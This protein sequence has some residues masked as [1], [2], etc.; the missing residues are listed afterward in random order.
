MNTYLVAKGGCVKGSLLRVM[1]GI[2][3]LWPNVGKAG[4]G[5]Q[6]E[7]SG[8][9]S[10][11]TTNAAPEGRGGGKL[12]LTRFVKIE[13]SSMSPALDL[14]SGDPIDYGDHIGICYDKKYDKN[15][16]LKH[17]SI[18]PKAPTS[19]YWNYR[20]GSGAILGVRKIPGI[21]YT[22][23]ISPGVVAQDGTVDEAAHEFSFTTPSPV[24]D[25]EPSRLT[26]GEPY[27]YGSLEHPFPFSLTGP[28]GDQQ[29]SLMARAGVRFARI[30]YP[31]GQIEP[32]KGVYD[33]KLTDSILD[34]LLAKGITEMP[35]LIQYSAASWATEARKYPAIWSTPEDYADFAG[36]VA[37]HL[38]EKYP[39]VTRIEL[40]NEPNLRGWWTHPNPNS[41]YADRTGKA[42][43]AYMLAAYK[44]IK[45][46]DPDLT[47]V[48][49]A[50][51]NGGT[52]TDSRKFLQEL[53]NEGCKQGN[54]W[55]VLSIHNEAWLNPNA[56]FGDD[57]TEARIDV[58]KDLL[59]VAARNGDTNAHIMWSEWGYSTIDNTDGF[60]PKVQAYFIGLAFNRMLADPR[61]DGVVYVNIYNPNSD[62][63]GMT[64]LVDKKFN[65]LPGFSMYQKFAKGS[66]DETLAKP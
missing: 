9:N 60:D 39:Q 52:H 11:S 51:S 66:S 24:P 19:F 29:I 64:S 53:Y 4:I 12:T 15:S 10:S 7:Y 58:Y 48:G 27:R 25:V 23:D 56:D 63:Y 43:A 17:F 1:V 14:N 8:S 37:A 50:L 65:P 38:K 54:G 62:F 30:D 34:R 21:K 31:G 18:T 33:F 35:C 2:V 41:P 47:V 13:A 45:A 3:L 26:P 49:P 44:A 32:Q 59:D 42:T 46:S 28:T 16:F 22:I 55:D 20:Y 57:K 36:H 40:F 61:V 6:T 5:D